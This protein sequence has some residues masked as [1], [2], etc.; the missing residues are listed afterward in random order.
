[1]FARVGLLAR[2]LTRPSLGFA[3]TSPTSTSFGVVT[4]GFKMS[5]VTADERNSRAIHTAACLII[6]D[7]VLGGKAGSRLQTD[8][9][10][11]GMNR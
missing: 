10:L 6:G 3:A 4:A 11:A 8:S 7:E 2:H 9:D 5:G 1:M